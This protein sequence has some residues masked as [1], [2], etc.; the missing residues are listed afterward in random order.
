MHNILYKLISVNNCKMSVS[1]LVDS[2]NW[3]H[4]W[5]HQI[6]T[7]HSSLSCLVFYLSY[8]LTLSMWFELFN[9]LVSFMLMQRNYRFF[10]LFV[11]TSTFL[12]VYVFTFSLINLLRR[13][14][15][16]LHSLSDDLVSVILV[17]YCFV[18]VWFVGGLTVFHFY[19]M[20]TNQVMI[21]NRKCVLF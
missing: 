9:Q 15:G 21:L 13:S 8:D 17:V 11:S 14:K 4:F 5:K 2:E 16:V 7:F 19:L 10:I 18:V 6:C 1:I 12:C 20:S 3:E